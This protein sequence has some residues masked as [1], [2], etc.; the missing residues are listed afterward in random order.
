MKRTATIEAHPDSGNLLVT[1]KEGRKVIKLF[2]FVYYIGNGDMLIYTA[3]NFIK[4][5]VIPTEE[6]GLIE[7]K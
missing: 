2:R 7:I 4:Y 5:G 1:F 6:K 3:T